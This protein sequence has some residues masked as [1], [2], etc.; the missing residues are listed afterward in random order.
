MIHPSHCQARVARTTR[1]AT[2]WAAVCA[3]ALYAV[4]TVATPAAAA[5]GE[6]HISSYDVVLSVERNGDL[7][8]RERIAYDFGSNDRHGIIREIP[9]RVPFDQDRDRVYRV[10]DIGVMSPS[11]APDDVEKSDDSG[12]TRLRIGD[13]DRTI[14]GEHLYEISYVVEGALNR[15]P[16]HVEL[17]WNAI[18]SEW[19]V[20]I[21]NPTVRAV[22]PGE[23]ERQACFTGPVGSTLPCASTGQGE[24]ANEVLFAQPGGLGAYEAVTVVVAMAPGTVSATGP[25]LEER[26][27]LARAFTPNVLTGTLTGVILLVGLGGILWLLSTRARDRR[28]VGQTPGLLP[29][30]TDQ[31]REEL[32]PLVDGAPVAVQFD[33]PEGLRPG[34][35]GTLLDEQA[36]VLDVTATIVDLAVRG[37]LR[38]EELPRAHWFASRDWKLVKLP[39]DR[40][41]LLAF[42]RELYDGLFEGGDTVLLSELKKTFSEK[43]GKVQTA[44]Y[45][46][47]TKAGWFRARPDM[48][49]AGWG[50][51]GFVGTF[52]GG[53]A[54]F[55]LAQHN[56]WGPVGV[57][58]TFVGVVM[59][60]ASRRMAA[61]TARGTAV[62]AQARGFREYIRSAEADQLRYE[63]RQDVFSRYL[64]YAVVF[65]ETERWVK[66]FAQ[67]GVVNQVGTASSWYSG[68]SGW[69]AD[70]FS[71]SLSG[72]TVSTSGA[73]AASTASSSGGSGFGGGG[74]SGGG[75][76]GGG[77]G[78]W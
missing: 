30:A 60:L 27:S 12:Y 29:G 50:A 5:D 63:E 66:A 15:F 1:A 58:L 36:N 42:E 16:D 69:D 20:T 77:G 51:L 67:L 31:R 62:L 78:S 40:A 22:V 25:I 46:D 75:G 56:H 28:F 76:G 68:P 53:W 52:G 8:V 2:R 37:Y 23:I 7:S 70:S 11:G 35:I 26:Y 44:L 71:D 38:I 17:Y 24:N 49:R 59:W 64:P 65:G 3:V 72:F 39:G 21:A 6:E 41:Q 73:M 32:V 14:T 43:L 61:R 13:P 10:R 9:T 55:A 34:Q 47:V 19:D 33:P 74:S 45:E 48:V 4:V 18:G 57:A 54:T